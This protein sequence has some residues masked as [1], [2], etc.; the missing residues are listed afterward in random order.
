MTKLLIVSMLAVTAALPA[1]WSAREKAAAARVNAHTLASHI[2]YLADDLLEG[3]APASRGSELAMRYIAAEYERL[4]LTPA[5][6]DG[7]WLQRFD[8]V[9]LESNV[10]TPITVAGGGK[11]LTLSPYVESVVAPGLQAESMAIRDA[12]SSVTASPRPSRSGTT[13]RASTC[14]ARSCSS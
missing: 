12:C 5:G 3:R 1:A 4:G 13:S 8:L 9:G 14:A 10:V 11:S 6:D 2:G 7:G